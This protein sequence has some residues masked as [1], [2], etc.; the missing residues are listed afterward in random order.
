MSNASQTV[1]LAFQA[2]STIKKGDRATV[3]G[4]RTPESDEQ[5]ATQLRLRE[6]GFVPGEQVRIVAVSFPGNDPIAVRLGNTTFALRRHE[7]AMVLVQP[8]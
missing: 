7:A 6:L 4:M 5:R 1:S 3:T 8:L 2:L